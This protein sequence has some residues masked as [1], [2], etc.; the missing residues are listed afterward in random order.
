MNA[1]NGDPNCEYLDFGGVAH[2][3]M[4]LSTDQA[5]HF[6]DGIH[7]FPCL[8]KGLRFHGD[9]SIPRSLRIHLDDMDEFIA[10]FRN[11]LRRST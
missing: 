8:G 3:L 6:V 9:P 11:F 10:R 7:G 5:S 2:G 4:G 1:P